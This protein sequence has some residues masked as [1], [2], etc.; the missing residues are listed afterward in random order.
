MRRPETRR[1]LLFTM[2]LNELDNLSLYS[3]PVRYVTLMVL[4]PEP[5]QTNTRL[6]LYTRSWI[7]WKQSSSLALMYHPFQDGNENPS[8]FSHF[9][10]LLLLPLS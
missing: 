1:R 2:L 5:Q 7:A 4:K 8:R 6:I 9:S 10:H 3:D